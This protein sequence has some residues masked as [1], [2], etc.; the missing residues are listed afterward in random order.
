[1]MITQPE[2]TELGKRLSSVLFPPAVFR[3]L[4]QSLADVLRQPQSE[5]SC[6]S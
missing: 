3:L 5:K 2:A 6:R 1:M 4:A